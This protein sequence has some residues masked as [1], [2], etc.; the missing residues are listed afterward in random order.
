MDVLLDIQIAVFVFC[1]GCVR[2]THVHVFLRS[3]FVAGI[4]IEYSRWAMHC[5]LVHVL[6]I[7]RAG[8]RA[9]IYTDGEDI[10]LRISG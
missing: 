5:E 7:P 3:W 8:E 4:I 9:Y 6:R 10:S 2:P 1:Q